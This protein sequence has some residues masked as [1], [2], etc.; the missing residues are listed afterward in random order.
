MVRAL[1]AACSGLLYLVQ[2]AS[3]RATTP[4]G[5]LAAGGFAN[6]SAQDAFCKGTDCEVLTIYDQSRRGNHL[7]TGFPGRHSPVDNGV[8][9][10]KH[11]ITISGHRVYGA[12][13]DVGMGYRNDNT[14]GIAVGQDPESMYAV[15][16]GGHYDDQCCFDYGNA[17]NQVGTS[18]FD[19]AGT[20]H[21]RLGLDFDCFP[22][23]FVRDV[24]NR[25]P[26]RA[27][28]LLVARRSSCCCA[29]RQ[30]ICL[31]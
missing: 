22:R 5:L 14:S 4:I 15:F 24:T 31:R 7:R 17:E 21:S 6:S 26:S 19:A 3:D 2:R 18:R 27:R 16:I 28:A 12:W 8:N 10:T 1:Y 11:P 13:F 25:V 20:M 23:R 9:A 30:A 29:H